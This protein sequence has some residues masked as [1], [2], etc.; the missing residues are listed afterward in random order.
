MRVA[1]A[2]QLQKHQAATKPVA[3]IIHSPIQAPKLAGWLSSHPASSSSNYVALSQ[4]SIINNIPNKVNDDEVASPTMVRTYGTNGPGRTSG[5]IE[6]VVEEGHGE[7]EVN[8]S[9]PL[10]GADASG[11]IEAVEEGSGSIRSSVGNLA[12]TIIGSGMIL[13]TASRSDSRSIFIIGMLTFPLVCPFKQW[14]SYL[15]N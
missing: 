9:A 13:R 7:H 14:Q 4:L 6:P 12:N 3:D 5:E 10:L 15:C 1:D 8:D 11:K 2:T